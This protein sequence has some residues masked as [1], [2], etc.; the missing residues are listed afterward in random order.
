MT[1][2][3]RF[4]RARGLTLVE[5]LVTL[6]LAA[7]L[8]ASVIAFLRDVETARER[9][10]A[11]SSRDRGVDA[12]FDAVERALATSTLDAVDGAAGVTGDATSVTIRSS[13]V[14]PALALA[15]SPRPFV[16]ATTTWFGFDEETQ[17][18]HVRRGANAVESLPVGAVSLRLRY[19][20]GADWVESFDARERGRLPAAVEVRVT[21]ASVSKGS[22][23]ADTTGDESADFAA[24]LDAGAEDEFD[25]PW[26]GEDDRAPSLDESPAAARPVRRRV[27][28]I[29]DAAPAELMPAAAR[30]DR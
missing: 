3:I 24:P 4:A 30:S 21:M 8:L 13:G 28:V 10:Q 18:L 25:A 29:P 15:P 6:G 23:P 11:R 7:A 26:R 22:A 9:I 5:L 12:F 16:A 17:A 27:I 14:E 1:K 19:H 2:R 20:D